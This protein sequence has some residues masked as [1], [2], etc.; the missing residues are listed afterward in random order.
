MYFNDLL[1]FEIQGYVESKLLYIFSLYPSLKN[2]AIYSRTQA[3]T[4]TTINDN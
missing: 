4:Q 2:M 3:L 1:Y